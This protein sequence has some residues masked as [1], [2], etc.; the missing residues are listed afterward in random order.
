MIILN[1]EEL[2]TRLS[3]SIRIPCLSLHIMAFPESVS[4]DR[5]HVPTFSAIYI[6]FLVVDL[7][8]CIYYFTVVVAAAVVA[9]L[10]F[11]I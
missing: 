6:Y 11:G 8:L 3:R 4:N 2:L 10:C 7:S 5:N 1:A 9:G